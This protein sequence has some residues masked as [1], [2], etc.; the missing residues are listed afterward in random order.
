[1][2]VYK[3][4]VHLNFLKRMFLTLV[5]FKMLTLLTK[6]DT[7]VASLL[8]AVDVCFVLVSAAYK[9]YLQ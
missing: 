3:C 9:Q 1:M 8:F 7:G 2:K 5:I 4:M 6:D